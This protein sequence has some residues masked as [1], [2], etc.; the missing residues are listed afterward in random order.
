MSLP[1][2]VLPLLVKCENNSMATTANNPITNN[3]AFA[4]LQLPD[5]ADTS[6]DDA[7]F[8]CA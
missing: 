7:D 3:F 1:I 5:H 4:I 8:V 6:A 2:V